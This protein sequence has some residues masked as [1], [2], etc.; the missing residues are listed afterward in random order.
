MATAHSTVR[1]TWSTPFL[2]ILHSALSPWRLRVAARQFISFHEKDRASAP[3]P[4]RICTR[5]RSSE[6]NPTIE[7]DKTEMI[8]FPN[9]MLLI[10]IILVHILRSE[11]LWIKGCGKSRAFCCAASLVSPLRLRTSMHRFIHKYLQLSIHRL[12]K[13]LLYSLIITKRKNTFVD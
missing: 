7:G 4:Y 11:D 9:Q 6:H 2:S 10:F 1:R 8:Q 13:G 12:G 3:L 5:L